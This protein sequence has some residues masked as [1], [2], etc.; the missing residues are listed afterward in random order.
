MKKTALSSV[1]ALLAILGVG[2]GPMVEGSGNVTSETR[3]VSGFDQVNLAGIGDLYVTQGDAE[4]LRI[5]AED[6]LIPYITSEVQGH[7]LEIGFKH[8][9]SVWPHRPV[10]FYL[11]LKDVSALR[12]S[13]SGNIQSERL[14][15]KD[16]QLTISGSGNIT[17]GQ[18]DVKS[19]S[20]TVSGS[21]NLRVNTV[22]ADSVKTTISG[23]GTCVLSGET[24]DQSA[25][26]T[27]SGDYKAF[28]LQ[29]QTASLNLSGSGNA[30]TW[31]TK[32]LDIRVVGSGNVKYYGAPTV[33]QQVVGSGNVS[34][35]GSH[36]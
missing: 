7:V 34:G 23:S 16:L 6:N 29:S 31:V 22:Q 21:G 17:V 10:K 5:E 12:V 32:D 19:L 3:Q 25:Q 2:C 11:T 27:G 9:V 26:V 35:L 24:A 8:M 36:E 4:S 20:N 14:A 18:L 1:F 33:S 30:Q 13:G 28:D 15:A